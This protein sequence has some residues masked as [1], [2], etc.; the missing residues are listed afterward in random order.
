MSDKPP[1]VG[2]TLSSGIQDVAALLP[3][4]G[5]E[6]CEQQVGSSLERGF[7]YAALAPLS[8][9][10]SLGIV[11]AAFAALLATITY[12][13][14]G[15]R[16][17]ADAGFAT[18]GSVSSMV[19]ISKDTGRYGAEVALEKLL[20]DLPIDDP[21]LVERIDWL[22]WKYDKPMPMERR[23][24]QEEGAQNPVT[25]R[26]DDTERGES[27]KHAAQTSGPAGHAKNNWV[28]TFKVYLFSWNILL[29]LSSFL[30]AL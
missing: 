21:T 30:S 20:K 12:P 11:K 5:T 18:P 27:T 22:G 14:Y 3:L 1:S 7:L 13:F 24:R 15:G 23:V 19:T 2:D 16:W 29:I 28:D 8:I 9:F 6:Q 10:G 4:L 25:D 26:S 17:L